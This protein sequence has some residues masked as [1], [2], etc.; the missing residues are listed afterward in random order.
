MRDRAKE[1]QKELHAPPV[2][3]GVY[4]YMAPLMAIKQ[5]VGRQGT[6]VLP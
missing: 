4:M 3:S 2:C 1:G 6:G 5:A